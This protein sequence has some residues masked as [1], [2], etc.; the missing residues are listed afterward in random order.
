MASAP[1]AVC[2]QAEAIDIEVDYWCRVKGQHLANDQPADDRNAERPTQFG[3]LAKADRERQRA[4]HRRHRRHHDW[5]EPFEAGLIDRLARAPTF[6]AF[7]IEREVD[8][9]NRVFL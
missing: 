5:P 6:A 8:H 2:R 1:A 3:T 7:G 4:E 9:H